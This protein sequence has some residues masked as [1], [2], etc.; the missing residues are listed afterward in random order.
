MLVVKPHLTSRLVLLLLLMMKFKSSSSIYICILILSILSLSVSTLAA[1]TPPTP[2]SDIPSSV[3]FPKTGEEKTIKI[4]SEKDFKLI[5]VSVGPGY[6][7]DSET[8]M[9]FQLKTTHKGKECVVKEFYHVRGRR[10]WDELMEKSNAGELVDFGYGGPNGPDGDGASLWAF[11]LVKKSAQTREGSPETP[12]RDDQT[13][14]GS[15]DDSR[16]RR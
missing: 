5:K 12:S 3:N 7:D 4:R 15:P 14:R 11:F 2:V 13:R 9:V 16:D 1:P 10:S 8:G 6:S